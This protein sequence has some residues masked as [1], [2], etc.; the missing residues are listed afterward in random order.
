MNER[1][2]WHLLE[3]TERSLDGRLDEPERTELNALLRRDAEARTLFAK[4]LHQHAELRLDE[5]LM[6][7]LTQPEAATP[8][9]PRGKSLLVS[10][11]VLRIAA[12]LAVL[13][14]AGVAWMLSTPRGGDAKTIATVIKAKQCKWAGSTLPTAEGSR[15]TAGTLELVEGI[16][17]VKFDSGAE[18]VMEAPATLE[19]TNAM[20]C[21]LVRGTL[22]AD[23]PPSAIGFTVDT[24]DAKV[25]DYGTR[26][27]V[28]TGEDGKYH[29]QVL[30]GLVEVNPKSKQE[31][32]KLRA[33]ESMDT[34]LRRSQLHPQ[35]T[36]QE[37]NKWQPAAILESADGWQ[38]VSTAFG[39]G[40]DS[41]IQSSGKMNI[42]GREPFFRVKHT[43]HAPEL[44]RKGYIGFDVSRFTMAD[45]E[46]AEL[47]L[48]IEPSD[49]GFA[50]LVPDSTF[51]VYGL[52]DE[53]QDEWEEKGLKWTEAP[54]QDP[55]QPARHLPMPDKTVLLGRFELAQ[56]VSRG[57][58]SVRGQALLDFLKQDTNGLVTF[59][60]CRETDESTR[61]G[62][63]HAFATKENGGNTP[64]LL[65]VKAKP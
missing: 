56:G 33:G 62:L 38:V 18:V 7:D 40:K 6:R 59:I 45:I 15:V 13:G 60:I 5:R 36:E 53:S 24:P 58:R 50:T 3:L 49:L 55:A 54:A 14:I 4:A 44:N 26:F 21:K 47:V 8:A 61:D 9:D 34:G 22:V 43:T 1:D 19:L 64:P 52:T 12:V 11:S 27:G 51:A 35:T 30:E 29:V 39:R 42:S 41:Y 10:L 46:E 28:S 32:K 17:T 25:V 20:A 31:P 65:R 37:P 57:T 63:A 2:Q 16:A 48:S 23:V